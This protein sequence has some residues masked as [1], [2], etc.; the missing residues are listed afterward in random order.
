M[1]DAD[2]TN[3][4][5][6]LKPTVHASAAKANADWMFVYLLRGIP[7]AH[8]FLNPE[9]SEF[10]IIQLTSSRVQGIVVECDSSKLE[11]HQPN[12]TQ[13]APLHQHANMLVET[14]LGMIGM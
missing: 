11:L 5:P 10:H 14:I 8:C 12:H 13:A 3:R 6:L 4:L 1:S 7:T 9:L 2:S